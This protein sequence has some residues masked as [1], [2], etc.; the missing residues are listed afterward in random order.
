MSDI[1]P[2]C[3]LPEDL[4]MCETIAL[5]AQKIRVKMVTRKYGKKATL[6]DGITGDVNIKDI[7]KKLK[8]KFACGGSHTKT[9]IE[10]QGNHIKHIK[11]ELIKLGFSTDSIEVQER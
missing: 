1:C 9:S 10:L 7:A 3:G 6:V 4:C 11:E 5:E 8:S 2:K